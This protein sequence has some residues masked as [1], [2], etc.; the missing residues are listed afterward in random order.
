M[1]ISYA[2]AEEKVMDPVTGRLLNVDFES[3]KLAGI[4]DVGELVVHMMRGPGFDDRPV[5]GLG[6]PPVISPGAA[7]SNAVA[8]ALGRRVPRLPLTPD[9]VLATLDALRREV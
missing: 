7:L 4:G 9:R 2:L 6:E 3:Y 1:G 5:V 8:N